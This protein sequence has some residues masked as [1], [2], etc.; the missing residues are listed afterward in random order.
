MIDC[1]AE[2][3]DRNWNLES[4]LKELVWNNDLGCSGKTASKFVDEVLPKTYNLQLRSLKLEGV[5]KP[6]AAVK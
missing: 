1:L 6:S 3:F 5:F 4:N 2:Q